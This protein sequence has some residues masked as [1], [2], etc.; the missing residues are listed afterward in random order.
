MITIILILLFGLNMF[1]VH[2]SIPTFRFSP[3][4]IFLQLMVP[5]KLSITTFGLYF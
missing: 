5:I 4:K 1:L 2:I 3:S